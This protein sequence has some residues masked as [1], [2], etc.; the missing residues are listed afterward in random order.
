MGQGQQEIALAAI[1]AA[2]KSGDWV[3]LKNL[4]LAVSWIP[5]LEK[6]LNTVEPNS[7]F[8]YEL[9]DGYTYVTCLT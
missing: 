4:H 2:M 7:N 1:T 6:I 5:V 8:R 3:I 9:H